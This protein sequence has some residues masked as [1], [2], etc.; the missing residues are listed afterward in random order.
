[1][2]TLPFHSRRPLAPMLCIGLAHILFSSTALAIV[3]DDFNDNSK[4]T[5]KWGAD[6]KSGQGVLTETNQRLEYTCS[7]LAESDC[8]RPW[9]LTRFPYN[10]DWEFQADFYN[11]STPAT[12]VEVNSMGFDIVSTKS[13]DNNLFTELYSSALSPFPG[14]SVY[15]T[16]F[17]SEI[18]SGNDTF[19]A[20]THGGSGVTNAAI[21]VVFDSATKVITMY[22][23]TEIS[24]GYQWEQHASFGVAGSGGSDGTVSWN[25][26]DT[27]QFAVLLY[28]YS[29]AMTVSGGLMY[30]DNFS[31]QGGIT[32]SGAA[33]PDPTGSFDFK[34]PTNSS[35]LTLIASIIGNYSGV[36]PTVFH[37]N[38]NIDVAQDETGKLT[39]M[40]TMDGIE[41]GNGSSDLT[42][43][44][45]S[46]KTVNDEPAAL[47]KGNFSG[48]R[49][50]E[51]TTFSG[52]A[53]L[54]LEVVDV[55]GGTNGLAGTGSYKSKVAGVPFSGKNF[56]VQ[57]AAPDGSEDNLKT[58]WSF[59]ID[60]QKK[61]IQGKERTVAS[62]QL[63]LPSGDTIVYPEK[64][65]KYSPKGYSLSFKGGT[66]TTVNPPKIDKKSSISIKGLTFV[67][68]G[69]DWKPTA[70]TISYQF[71]GQKGT[72]N[73]M[74]FV[75][76]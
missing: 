56:P 60:L 46:V 27:D 49:D 67:Q 73:L 19:V 33:I 24:D 12:Y 22:V 3:G 5:T 70:G 31:E 72:A 50:S 7:V 29:A 25:L 34:S 9:I 53:M 51:T 75:E 68:Q 38:Y 1:M 11:V 6:Q 63:T 39:A 26:T 69:A 23:D 59:H 74:D 10:A 8:N 17:Y 13:S 20:D 55:G 35:L 66:N 76:P 36:T 4:S 58:D 62:A 41:D 44:V 65:V 2:I 40:G 61:T 30:A 54:P 42:L 43:P 14:P 21:R 15:R 47:L 57:F 18:D 28:G 64:V 16:G 32:P 52:T 45:G 48:T 71:L 37:R